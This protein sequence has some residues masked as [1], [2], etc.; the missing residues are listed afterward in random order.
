MTVHSKFSQF[1]KEIEQEKAARAAELEAQ[2]KADDKKAAEVHAAKEKLERSFKTAAQ[3]IVQPVVD[4]INQWC[5]ANG[6]GKLTKPELSL[7]DGQI[8]M[9]YEKGDFYKN[10]DYDGD[11]FVSLYGDKQGV[12]AI[13]KINFV[14]TFSNEGA[15]EISFGVTQYVRYDAAN[16]YS[17]RYSDWK[18]ESSDRT[19]V[20]A[21]LSPQRE[22]PEA[23]YRQ[24]A[25]QLAS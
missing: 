20:K 5:L 19:L 21:D 25:Q 18:T 2:R 4:S 6:K 16:P 14:V 11:A 3:E 8:T 15:S 7:K 13:T 23:F 17:D 1:V 22:V 10:R 12:A 9:S 24:V